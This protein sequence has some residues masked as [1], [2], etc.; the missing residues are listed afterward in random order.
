[1]VTN[2]TLKTKPRPGLATLKPQHWGGGDVREKWLSEKSQVSS[3]SQKS[4]ALVQ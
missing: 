3:T 4:E 2:E 1:M